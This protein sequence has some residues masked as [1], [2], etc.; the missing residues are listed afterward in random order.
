[1]ITTIKFRARR[2]INDEFC[3][4]DLVHDYTGNT[5]II[6]DNGDYA[7]KPDSVSLLVGYDPTGNEIYDRDVLPDHIDGRVLSADLT[8]TFHDI[9]G[10]SFFPLKDYKWL[11]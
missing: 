4:G 6:S 11:Y 10:K 8:L 7:V 5:F 2:I 1:M 3:Y 9:H